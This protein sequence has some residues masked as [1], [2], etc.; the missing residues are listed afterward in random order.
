MEPM[1]LFR[2]LIYGN[3]IPTAGFLSRQTLSLYC[4]TQVKRY[5]RAVV[6]KT[7][8]YEVTFIYLFLLNLIEMAS[9]P[10]SLTN[11]QLYLD[12]FLYLTHIFL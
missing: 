4:T 7:K 2:S 3:F 10:I 5:R 1:R 12:S 8:C 9:A 11:I 6:Q